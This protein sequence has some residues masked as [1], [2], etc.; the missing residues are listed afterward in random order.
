[1]NLE[2]TQYVIDGEYVCMG[3]HVGVH[4]DGLKDGLLNALMSG[5]T[6]NGCMSIDILA[7]GLLPAT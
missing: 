3:F 5:V 1:M 7:S 2:Y 4:L 6:C